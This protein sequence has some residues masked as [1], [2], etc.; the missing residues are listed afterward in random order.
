MTWTIG[1]GVL[2]SEQGEKERKINDNDPSTFKRKIQCAGV[3]HQG[4]FQLRAF[5]VVFRVCVCV[6]VLAC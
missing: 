4:F 6:C 5:A 2:Q 1:L 3:G